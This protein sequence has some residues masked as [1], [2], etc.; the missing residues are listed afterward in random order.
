[1]LRY[2]HDSG[3]SRVVRCY[4]PRNGEWMRMPQM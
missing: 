2:G 3:R 1:M 4:D